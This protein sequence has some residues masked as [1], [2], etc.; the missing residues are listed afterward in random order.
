VK[1]G[2]HASSM[3]EAKALHNFEALQSFEH[4]SNVTGE[5]CEILNKD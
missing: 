4:Q 5:I 3:G 1:Y 2:K